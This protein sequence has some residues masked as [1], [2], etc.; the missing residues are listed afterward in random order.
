VWSPY[1]AD[2]GGCVAF[3][4]KQC[5]RSHAHLVGVDVSGRLLSLLVALQWT[6]VDIG[7]VV[8]EIMECLCWW[9][10]FLEL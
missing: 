9:I 4:V 6:K 3:E 2:E 1:P 8:E 7:V 5:G 10:Y